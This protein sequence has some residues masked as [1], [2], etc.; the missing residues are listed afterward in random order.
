MFAAV[1]FTYR[2]GTKLNSALPGVVGQLVSD[3][4]QGIALVHLHR[5]EWLANAPQGHPLATLWRPE[6]CGVTHD[7]FILRGLQ[8]APG[9]PRRWMAQKWICE[10]LDQPRARMR[11]AEP[12]R[13]FGAIEPTIR[14]LEEQP[15][16]S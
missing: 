10:V 11:L 3:R 1:Q 16:D 9:T 5:L 8:L 12:D 15:E 4:V 13:R 14:S 2:D 7:S 6:F